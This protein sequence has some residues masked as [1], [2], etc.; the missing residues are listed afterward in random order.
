[1]HF[2]CCVTLIQSLLSLWNRICCY[3]DVPSFVCDLIFLS[4]SVQQPFFDSV[5]WLTV[6]LCW[7][8]VSWSFLFG[9]LYLSLT[10]MDVSFLGLGKLSSMVL[11]KRCSVPLTWV[12]FLSSRP[13]I[14]KF[15]VIVFS[16]SSF[17]FHFWNFFLLL[18]IEFFFSHNIT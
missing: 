15:D 9:V 12:Y 2:P 10:L 13:I 16:Q 7:G 8:C 4:C 6:I 17:I 18:K 5:C 11:L 3:S 14:Y 1:M